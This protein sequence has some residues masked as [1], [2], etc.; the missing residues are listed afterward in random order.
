MHFANDKRKATCNKCG[1]VSEGSAGCS[2]ASCGGFFVITKAVPTFDV[3]SSLKGY[4]EPEWGPCGYDNLASITAAR[5]VIRNLRAL[6]PTTHI[7]RI[8]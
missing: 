4:S 7:Y 1:V 2:H 8:C 5:S 6:P 3:E